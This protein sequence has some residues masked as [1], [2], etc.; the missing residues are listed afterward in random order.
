MT[1]QIQ[2]RP[3]GSI[4]TAA[5][6]ARAR[7]LRSQQAHDLTRRATGHGFRVTKI[8]AVCAVAVLLVLP[9]LH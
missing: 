8:L 6:I 7:H 4:D 5:Y 9:A 2:T 1:S 3:D